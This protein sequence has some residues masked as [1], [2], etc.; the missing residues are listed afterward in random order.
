MTHPRARLLP[1]AQAGEVLEA[2][3][4]S[5]LSAKVAHMIMIGDHKQLR[6]KVETHALT[7]AANN[8]FNLNCSLFERLILGGLPHETLLTQHR[9]R[10][11]I[12]SIAR[13]M[14]YPELCDHE[15]VLDRPGMRGLAANVC[16]INH[17][18]LEQGELGD[19]LGFKSLSKVN[20]FEAD[21]AVQV[22]QYLLLQGYR[23]DSIV[24]LTPYLGQLKVLNDKFRRHVIV[25]RFFPHHLLSRSS[26]NGVL[27]HGC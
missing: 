27:A 1:H 21:M 3:V 14:T 10:P 19:G 9:M 25:A 24:V 6:P 7:V 23:S 16:F 13:H 12:S 2:H 15:S 18:Q 11:E 4:I 8:G 26:V 5:S 20:E 17:S 22:V